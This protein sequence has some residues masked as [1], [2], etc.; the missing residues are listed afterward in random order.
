MN[1]P[2]LARILDLQRELNVRAELYEE[3]DRLTLELKADGF[4]QGE[5]DGTL[6]DLVDNFANGNTVFRVAGVK[7]YEIKER[8][9]KKV[10][11]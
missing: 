6:Y 2:K 9:V 7:H 11:G 3:L 10:K 8:K 5:V 1:N 4:T